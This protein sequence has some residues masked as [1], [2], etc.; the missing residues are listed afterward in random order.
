MVLAGAT[1]TRQLLAVSREPYEALI[2]VASRRMVDFVV[3]ALEMSPSVERV[4]VIGPV[5]E[6]K[7][8]EQGKVKAVIPCGDTLMQN[9]SLALDWLKP[10][11]FVLVAT[12]DIPLL[13][14]EAVEDFL[15]QAA[16]TEADFYYSIVEKGVGEARYPGVKRTYVRL[17]DG[18]FT[19]GNLLLFHPRICERAWGFAEEMVRLRKEPFKM[20]RVLGW[21]FVLRLLLGRLTITQVERRFTQL[22]GAKGKAIISPYPEVGIDVDKPSDYELVLK[23]MGKSS[24]S[25][26]AGAK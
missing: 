14:P 7:D 19:G 8:L 15:R 22:V 18:T 21:S 3:A 25:G 5:P 20:C 26:S 4:V 11:G 1:N 12:S 10:A 9:L 16:A 13:T 17:K 6:L 23:S 24:M 2:P